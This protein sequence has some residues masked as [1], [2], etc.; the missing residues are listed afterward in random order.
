M[1]AQQAVEYGIIDKVLEPAGTD[2]ENDAGD[3]KKDK[4]TKKTK[5][6]KKST[7]K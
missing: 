3:D 5:K 1:T 7:K 4:K 2:D 6:T